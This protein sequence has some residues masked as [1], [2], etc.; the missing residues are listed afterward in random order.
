MAAIL[1]MLGS[2]RRCCDG[3]TR[4]ETLAAGAL[5][6]LGGALNLEGLLAA[7]AAG[8][9]KQGK[10][11]NV[12]LL[13]LLGGAATQDMYDLKPHAPSGIKTE[14]SP[15]STNVPG[16]QVCEHLPK[17]AQ[18]MHR[19]AL[20]RSLNHKAG[21]HNC[22]PSYSGFEGSVPDQHPRDTDPPS[23]GSV[24]EYLNER[25]GPDE[26]PA[27]V[28]MPNWLGWGQT[29]RRAGPY[30][31]FLGKRYDAFTTECVPTMD[32]GRQPAVGKPA[33]VRG[34]PL[35]PDSNLPAEITVDRLNHRKDLLRQIDDEHRRL[36]NTGVVERFSEIQQRAFGLLG[37][38]KLTDAFN[39]GKEPVQ[40]VE[41]YGNTLFGN[42]AL[43]A[44]RLVER[45]VRFVN[46]T[47][48]LYERP[49]MIDFDAWDTHRN[50]FSILKE[51]KLP[52]FDQVYSA[53]LEDLEARGMLDETLVL[54]T[55]EMGRTPRVNGNAGRDHWTYCY[56]SMLAGAGI[57]GGGV[58]GASDATAA[59]VKDR[60]VSSTEICATVY[61]LLGIGAETRVYD[62]LSRP[63]PVGMGAQPIRELLA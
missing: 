2:R 40:V 16:I 9:A 20:I 17:T 43:V 12:I 50:N 60:P 7:E 62:R 34:V 47:F 61:E 58:V 42:S 15:I 19:T 1:R 46:V 21:C 29:F 39:L 55:S 32:P 26:L 31:G 22:L 6:F 38:S 63:Y 24:C 41:R 11:K 59:Y 3:L 27:Y 10:A 4:R 48:D 30:G 57:K 36:E 13:Y 33:T 44:R 5:T 28:Y 51:N 45:G 54:V 35:L 25:S 49:T 8:D 56:G 23:M 18:W 14:F 53:L 52:V 37:A